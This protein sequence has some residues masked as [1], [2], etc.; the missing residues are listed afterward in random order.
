ML[1]YTEK[2][3]VEMLNSRKLKTAYVE[4]SSEYSKFHV[5]KF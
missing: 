5:I 2:I 1:F 4:T 3:C